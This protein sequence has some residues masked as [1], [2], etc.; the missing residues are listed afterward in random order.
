[1][2]PRIC[3]LLF[4]G[5]VSACGETATPDGFQLGFR[6]TADEAT[7]VDIP[8]RIGLLPGSTFNFYRPSRGAMRDGIS[9][10]VS[11]VEVRAASV[12]SV[13]V[14]A[15]TVGDAT[16]TLRLER[17]VRE[18]NE[19]L[20]DYEVV[21]SEAVEAT[22]LIG[23]RHPTHIRFEGPP[24]PWFITSSSATIGYQLSDG[25]WDLLGISPSLWRSRTVDIEDRVDG[26]WREI[27]LSAG[28]GDHVLETQVPGYE[29]VELRRGDRDEIDGVELDVTT[30]EL[31]V[32]QLALVRGYVL[33][34]A[35]R[36][37]ELAPDVT[38]GPPEVCDGGG[39]DDDFG[40]TL[41]LHFV[42]PGD[43]VIRGDFEGRRLTEE[44]LSV[45]V[46]N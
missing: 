22:T 27:R 43:C 45:T 30:A 44:T 21:G 11:V 12:E 28:R 18:W 15:K 46:A 13:V 4:F 14:E 20:Q 6:S 40:P 16:L 36:S 24:P 42:G 41:W 23:V 26:Q 8:A 10:D 17:D 35:F 25:D 1:M 7:T 39:D 2:Y 33:A 38:A 9:S 19:A 3:C 31:V 32:G 29:Q 34:G 5:V 37:L